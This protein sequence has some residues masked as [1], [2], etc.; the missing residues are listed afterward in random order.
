MANKKHLAILKKALHAENISIWN[1]WQEKHPDILPDLA[2]ANFFGADL[3][4]ADLCRAGWMG[5]PCHGD[6]M[7]VCHNIRE[8]PACR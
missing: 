2:G 5:A 4:A 8:F 1:A 3:D 6:V 7:M